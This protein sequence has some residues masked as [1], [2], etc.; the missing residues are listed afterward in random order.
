MKV[1]ENIQGQTL[2]EIADSYFA[3]K[4]KVECDGYRSYLKL[5]GVQLDP[6]N[7]KPVICIGST[8]QSAI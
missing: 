8:R 1:V 2:Q 6:K 7:M 4:S 5:D 3:P